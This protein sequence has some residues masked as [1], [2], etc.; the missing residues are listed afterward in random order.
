MVKKGCRKTEK[1]ID[2]ATL[3]NKVPLIIIIHCCD[4]DNKME[5]ENDKYPDT[6]YHLSPPPVVTKENPWTFINPVQNQ[7]M[8]C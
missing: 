7:N 2:G 1:M 3:D 5:I 6:K 4:D 8:V